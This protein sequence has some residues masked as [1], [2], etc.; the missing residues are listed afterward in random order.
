MSR[1]RHSSQQQQKKHKRCSHHDCRRKQKVAQLIEI[2]KDNISSKI[3]VSITSDGPVD[4][5]VMFDPSVFEAKPSA[6]LSPASPG[7]TYS[8]SAWDSPFSPTV[9]HLPSP[10]FIND[11]PF[12]L[13]ILKEKPIE[14]S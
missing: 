13:N 7:L 1:R 4:T 11:I 12:N 14:D 5:T 10:S 3:L 2:S 6:V 8:S 9:P